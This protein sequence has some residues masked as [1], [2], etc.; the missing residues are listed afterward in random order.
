MAAFGQAAP[1]DWFDGSSVDEIAFSEYVLY[2]H[3]MRCI[4]DRLYDIDGLLSDAAVQSE[5]LE[6]VRP[7][8]KSNVAKN[9]E[10]YLNALKLAAYCPELPIQEDRIHFQNGTYFIEDRR[11]TPEKEFCLN[12]LPVRYDPEAPVPERWLKFLGELLYPEDIPT[13]QE[14]MGYTLLPS[15]KGQ[16]MMIIIGNGG[17]GKSRIGRVLRAILGDNMNTTAIDKLS[18]DKF[19]RADQEGKLLMLDDDMKLQAL[20]DTNI[21]KAII[22]MEDKMD[23]ERKNMQSYQGFL[24]VRLLGLGNGSL[25]ALYDRSDG[26]YR[27]Q[28]VLNVRE[29]EAGRVDDRR[30]GEK[31][32]AEAE[33][34]LLWELE[35]LHR[36]LANDYAFTISDRAAGNIEAAKKEDNN[37]LDFLA[38]EGYVRFEQNTHATSRQLYTA[39]RRWCDDNVEKPFAE[40]TFTGYLK[41][42]EERLKLKY[43]Q[44]I[45]TGDGKTAR[46]Y[47]GIHVQ[48][49]TDAPGQYRFS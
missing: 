21:L 20:D 2:K 19:C 44:N 32:R 1:P 14:F 16:K 34:I 35:G 3:P 6:Y 36:L 5:I 30:L 7:Y 49:N 33:G 29:K 10:K 11:F 27:R 48:I 15:N 12:R 26:F 23:L 24:Y 47:M 45:P 40:K 22:T 9:V 43:T 25:S 38:S 8:V 18:K 13:L 42:N 37:I 39:Y 31:L 17:E 4:H 28:I 41:K 46:G